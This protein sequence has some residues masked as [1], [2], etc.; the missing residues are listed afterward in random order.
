M[1][2][3]FFV[4]CSVFS[5]E[6]RQSPTFSLQSFSP[7]TLALAAKDSSGPSRRSSPSPCSRSFPT[8]RTSLASTAPSGGLPP[9]S[10]SS[11]PSCSSVC[12]KQRTLVWKMCQVGAFINKL[13]SNDF[14]GGSQAAASNTELSCQMTAAA[15]LKRI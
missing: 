2:T 8:W 14:G 10:F 3:I 11:S 5:W 4:R 12:Q 1:Q 9:S 7:T 6:S 13:Q 15:T